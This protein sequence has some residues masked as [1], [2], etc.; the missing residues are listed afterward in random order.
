LQSDA[1]VHRGYPCLLPA[2]LRLNTLRKN[3]ADKSPGKEPEATS[4]GS[5]S[6]CLT[7]LSEVSTGF[8]Q[9]LPRNKAKIGNCLPA[10]RRLP[11]PAYMRLS[12]I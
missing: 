7:F 4:S 6:T 1:V 3:I 11:P 12:Q 5:W 8:C 9:Q 2:L 10:V